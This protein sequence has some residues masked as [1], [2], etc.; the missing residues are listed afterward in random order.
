[1]TKIWLRLGG[2]ITAD[3]ETIQSIKKGDEQALVKAIKENGFEVNGDTYIPD[4]EV[5]F[6]NEVDF[7]L[8]PI[9]L[10]SKK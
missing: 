2:Y 1:M 6:G 5:D 10:V 4:P 9:V 3:Q 7:N 8:D